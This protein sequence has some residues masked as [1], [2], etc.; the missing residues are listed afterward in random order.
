LTEPVKTPQRTS[1]LA[2]ITLAASVIALLAAV[3]ST[4]VSLAALR[5]ANAAKEAAAD[6]G[7]IADNRGTGNNPAPNQQATNPQPAANSPRPS[8]T[9]PPLLDERTS[10]TVKYTKQS[11][12]MSGSCSY[13]SGTS[14][15]VDLDEPRANVD[16]DGADFQF[17]SGCN[18]SEPAAFFLGRNVNGGLVDNPN[19]TPQE[20]TDR[21]RRA[22]VGDASIPV[23]QG[24]A[25]CLT[26]SYSA[27]RARGDLWRVVLIVVTG[28]PDQRTVTVEATAWNIPTSL[29]RSG[30]QV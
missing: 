13:S 17:R 5:Q 4:A 15:Y 11:L 12:T 21:I 2:I 26:T 1:L 8:L 25:I 30:A 29:S 19:A 23:R 22:P 24:A 10:Y 18:S 7:G 16:D 3:S 9:G 14:M 28:V 27:A 20:C 6:S